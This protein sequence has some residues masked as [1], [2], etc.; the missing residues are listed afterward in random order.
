MLKEDTEIFN[1]YKIN[2][3]ENTPILA[4]TNIAYFEN[5]NKTL[6]LGMN[7]SEDILIDNNLIDLELK[8][9]QELKL[10]TYEDLNDELSDIIIKTMKIE[11]YDLK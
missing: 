9:E 11:E 5:N 8:E 6:P 10:V 2:L 1:L 4:F 7:V 3:K